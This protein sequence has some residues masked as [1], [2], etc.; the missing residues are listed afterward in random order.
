LLEPGP[1]AWPISART[2]P[3]HGSGRRGRLGP[4][5]RSPVRIPKG[6]IR[7]RAARSCHLWNS[8]NLWCRLYVGRRRLRRPLF[9][10]RRTIA[11]NHA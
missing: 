1:R 10:S 2:D 6:P 7:S 11:G 5:D 3:R 8:G 4:Q 9:Q